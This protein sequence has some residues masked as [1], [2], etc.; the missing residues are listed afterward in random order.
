MAF[1]DI[2]DNENYFSS[3]Y[4][5]LRR[6]FAISDR[7]T[8]EEIWYKIQNL[9]EIQIDPLRI[10][11]V[12]YRPFEKKNLYYGNSMGIITHPR[13]E[14]M[15]HILPWYWRFTIVELNKV[16]ADYPPNTLLK[17]IQTAERN[18]FE[19][20][21]NAKFLA[22]LNLWRVALYI[23]QQGKAIQLNLF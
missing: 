14:T 22:N 4:E 19:L 10:I 18:W 6:Y 20:P 7:D 21:L 11:E 12:N 17:I 23:R 1:Y 8:D 15:K 5:M 16:M 9:G 3:V 13:Y 2:G